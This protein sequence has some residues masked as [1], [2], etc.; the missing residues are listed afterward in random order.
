MRKPQ[1]Y[2][3]AFL[4]LFLSFIS[5]AHAGNERWQWALSP[6]YAPRSSVS[7]KGQLIF[8]PQGQLDSEGMLYRYDTRFSVWRDRNPFALRNYV[9]ESEDNFYVGYAFQN[10]PWRARIFAGPSVTS[11]NQFGFT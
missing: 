8:S 10:G 11:D 4:T 3:A 7:V 6:F 2:A 5:E 1:K 9:T